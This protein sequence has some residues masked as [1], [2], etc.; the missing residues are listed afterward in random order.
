MM[1][2]LDLPA[3]RA[4]TL[5]LQA[6]VGATITLRLLAGDDLTGTL[7]SVAEDTVTLTAGATVWTVPIVRIVALGAA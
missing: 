4:L 2:N 6:Q 5:A 7:A 1:S 3:R